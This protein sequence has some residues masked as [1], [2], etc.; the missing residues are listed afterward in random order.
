MAGKYDYNEKTRAEN[1]INRK[2]DALKVAITRVAEDLRPLELV[3]GPLEEAWKE[4]DKDC[5]SPA[6]TMTDW[7]WLIIGVIL[8][9]AIVLGWYSLIGWM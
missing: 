2:L 7:R 3:L 4:E 6:Y 9:V 8:G 5:R 1:A